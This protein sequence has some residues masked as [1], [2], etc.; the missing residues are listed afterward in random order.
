MKKQDWAIVVFLFLL[1]LGWM[2]FFPRFFPAAPQA[3]RPRAETQA[4]RRPDADRL[5]ADSDE[6]EPALAAPTAAARAATPDTAPSAAPE[7]DPPDPSDAPVETVTIANDRIQA[8]FSSRGA[9]LVKVVLPGYRRELARDSGPVELDFREAPA[10]ALRGLAG[11][12]AQ[13]GFRVVE[14]GPDRVTFERATRQG[15]LLRRT[16]ALSND[17]QIAVSDTFVNTGETDLLLPESWISLGPLGAVGKETT[18]GIAYLGVDAY[19]STG[20][21][22]VIHWA[23]RLAGLFADEKKARELDRL[24]DRI[25]KRQPVPV[26]WVAVKSKFF[27][28]I[29]TPARDLAAAYSLRAARKRLPGEGEDPSVKVKNAEVETVAA[30]VQLADARVA[31]GQSATRDLVY[32]AGPKKYA[33][34]K[35]LGLG[36]EEVMEF[37]WWSVV[38][39]VLLVT[40]NAIYAVVPNYGVAII[41]LTILVRIVFWPVTHKS[42]ESMKKMQALQPLMAEL[43]TKYKDNPKKLQEETMLLY[44][45]HKV[46]P[47]SG[48]LPMLIQ[49][50]VFIALFVVLRS[51]IELRF[52]RFLWVQDLS[53]PENL[54]AG[55]LPFGFSLNIL[56]LL[57]VATMFLQQKLSPAGGDPA[58]QRMM[59]VIMPVMMLV[60]FYNMASGLILYWT[61]SN[62][63]MIVQQLMAKLRSRNPPAPAPA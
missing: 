16:F 21:E 51:A 3:P 8:V 40:L 63:L 39:K 48:C 20:G 15:F 57:M 24:P 28:Q 50:P 10:L 62:V 11:L 7:E 52:A 26:Y 9:S 6:I 2:V 58:Q 41:L 49:I 25:L 22:K 37:G 31:P 12:T 36:Q 23:D 55:L 18:A 13:H 59:M 45:K 43:R 61:V 60:F 47:V 4:D 53:E 30:D 27:V 46:N 44:K 29:L 17:Y 54:L 34:L 35:T 5:R 1:L 32:Y 33:I 19:P 56:P 42:T 38:C 14:R